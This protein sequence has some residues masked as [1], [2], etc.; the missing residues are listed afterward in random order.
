M[1]VF[2]VLHAARWN[3][4]RRNYAKSPSAHHRTALSRYNS[5][6]RHIST[7]GKRL[8]KQQYLHTCSQFGEL[9]LTNG[10]DRLVSLGHPM[11]QI[12][13]G[14]ASRRRYCS[15]VAQRR[16]TKLCTMFG[17]LVAVHYIHFWRLLSRNGILTGEKFTL[18]PNLAFF[19]IGSVTARHSSSGR[20]PN[21]DV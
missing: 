13:T 3:T 19:Y 17:R 12:S 6:L 4:G 15:D 16:S 11:Q 21:C 14:F 20:Q 8:V 1:N 9:R 10:R 18:R 7:M 5:Q 2:N